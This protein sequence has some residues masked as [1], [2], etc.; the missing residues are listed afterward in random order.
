[1]LPNSASR[2]APA[3]SSS[4]AAPRSPDVSSS[5]SLSKSGPVSG[6]SSSAGTAGLSSF[7]VDS[8]Q[9]AHEEAV[10]SVGARVAA[11]AGR[12][13]R[14]GRKQSYFPPQ[15]GAWAFIG[16][17]VVVGFVVADW[18]PLLLCV[19]VAAIAAFPFSH[20]LTAILR[21]PHKERYVQPLALWFAVAG[22]P[23]LVC[24]VFRPWLL[25]VGLAYIAV[26]AINVAFARHRLERSLA[27]DLVFIVECV[28]LIPVMWGIGATSQIFALPS[29]SSSPVAMWALALL[30]LLA[31]VGSTLHVKSLIRE[32]NNPHYPPLSL[33]WAVLCIPTAYLLGLA[34][35]TAAWVLVIPYVY[36]LIRA[37]AL[38]S[39]SLKPGI[40]GV[41]ELGGFL[42]LFVAVV[43]VAH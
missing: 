42:L 28:A 25:F 21:Y 22:I 7:D 17:P 36:L 27:N 3:A 5:V 16:L 31:M 11:R 14:A 18:T 15:H 41:V 30:C 10:S 26:F 40:I 24:V 35:D 6:Q 33:A 12:S 20:F 29:W 9:S 34:I 8:P 38:R 23:A 2:S 19:A 4:A 13:A 1:M 39:R 32:R 37:V 43:V